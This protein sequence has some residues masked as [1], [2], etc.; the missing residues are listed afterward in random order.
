VG[1]GQRS[2][3]IKINGVVDNTAFLYVTA[4]LVEDFSGMTREQLANA[5]LMKL[6]NQIF[7]IGKMP[8]NQTK[9][10][11]FKFTNTGKS[12][13]IIRSYTG[14]LWLYGLAAG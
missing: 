7:D 1:I 9:E 2:G 14:N 11:E 12:D 8:V 13:L 10:V 3:Q 5:P 4:S 6:E